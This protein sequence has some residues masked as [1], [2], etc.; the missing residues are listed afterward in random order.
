MMIAAHT[1]LL[2]VAL[3]LLSLAHVLS[4]QTTNA[5]QQ[6]AFAGLRSIAQ[7]GQVNGVKADAAGNLFL[8]LNQGDGVRLLKTDNAGNA[9]LAQ[10]RLGAA[11]D[12]GTALALDPAGNVFVA[13]T[14][15]SSAM[16]ATPGAAIAAR[17]DSST[18]S[19]VARFDTSLNPVF[20]TFTG[21][22]RIAATSVA[23]TADA[24]FVSGIT[25][26]SNLPV[27]PHG[28]QQSPAFASTQNGFVEKFSASGT[29]LLYATY[30]TGA[31]GDTTPQALVA[32]SAD[33]LYIAGETTASG[34][35]TVAALVPE[36]LSNPSGFLTKLTPAG[37][38]ILFSTFVPGNGLTSL[39]LDS[40][41]STLLASGSVNLGQFP[42]DMV[43]SL[44][45]P[46][47]AYQ[48]LLRLPTSGSSVLSA[49]LL[50]PA[51]ASFVAAAP[52]G[53]AWTAGTM[54]APMLPLQPLASVGDGFAIHTTGS[55][56]VD[57]TARFGGLPNQSPSYASLPTLLTAITA[58]PAG[59]AIVAGA[60]QPTA[61]SA[62]LASETYDLPLRNSSTPA[63]PS[64][65]V[66]AELPSSAC[67]GSLCAGSAAFLAKL[68]PNTAAPALAFS[69]GD[70]PFVVLRN[71]GS[72]EATN[73]QLAANTS[74]LSS[75]CP[76]NLPAGGECELLLSGGGAGDLTATT[77]NAGSQSVSLPA[78]SASAPLSSIVFL[79]K[80]LDFGIQTS[81]SPAST[82]ILTISNL[83]SVS[84]TFT[85]ALD[86]TSNPKNP[87]TYPFTEASSDCPSAGNALKVLAAGASCHITI[88]F[89]AP[90]DAT[91]EGFVTYNWLIGARDVKL[92]GYEQAA[93]LSASASQ[94]DFG[95]QFG[96]VS[97][98][99]IHLPRYLFLSNAS[100][101]PIAHTPVSLPAGSAFT[102]TDA[103]PLSL[104]AGTV[105]RIRIDY[106]GSR[107]TSSDSA[108]LALDQG[109]SVLLTGRTLPPATTTGASV[110]P[111]LT[112]TPSS[113][114]FANAVV[115][116]GVSGET[117]TVTIANTG[118]SAFALSLSL[119]GD[120]TDSTSCGATLAGGQTCAVVLSFV[121]TAPGQRQGLLAVTAGAGTTPFYVSITASATGLLPANNG[122]LDFGS[123]TVNQPVTKFFKVSQPLDSFSA[124]ATGPYGII[125]VEEAGFGPGNPP[126]SSFASS[127]TGS[128]HN[129]YLGIQ[130]R[131][132]AV[133]P[134]PG[135]LTL[136][137]V[138]GGSPYVLSLTGTGL[139]LAGLLLT[140]VTQDFG[141]VPLH[142]ASG[143][144]LFTLT[145]LIP[146]ASSVTLSGPSVSGDFSL[147]S[148][149]TGAPSCAGTL[150]Y[151]TSCIVAVTFSP[152]A[153]GTRTGSL[154]LSGGGF[155]V[156]AAL[157]GQ[158]TADPGLAINPLALTFAN[159]PGST[160][161]QQN[162]TLTNTGSAALEVGT[163]VSSSA[164]FSTSSPCGSLA[165]GA[166]C[167]I[168]V[169]FLPGSAIASGTLSIPVTSPPGSS[170]AVTYPVALSG[171]YTSASAGIQIVP[172]Q[173][174][175]GPFPVDSFGTER[176]YTLNNLTS[177]SLTLAVDIPRNFVLTSAPCGGLAPNA[178]CSFQL[179]FV[180]LTA[181]T[182]PG[183]IA[184]QGTPS[185]GSSP[186]ATFGYA[187]GYGT[188]SGA[189]TVTGG[190]LVNGVYDFGQVTSG[191]AV[192]H[193]FTLTNNNP[194]GSPALTVRRITS[195]PPFLATTN[196]GSA[197]AV[198]QGCTV[199]V[200]YT[201]V[202]QVA[203]GTSSAP[204]N[205]DAGT[206]TI[207]SD[208]ASSPNIINLT[209]RASPLS[210]S[211]PVNPA[212]LATFTLTQGSL[213]FPL[214]TVGNVSAAQTI[215]LA[216]TGTATLHVGG[217]FTSSD[218]GVVSDCTTVLPGA[219]C[220]IDVTAQPQSAGPHI[221]SLEISSDAATALEF[222]SLF[223]TGAASPLVF[224]PASLDFGSVL[225]GASST[226]HVQ[227]TNTSAAAITFNS[228]AGFG[229]YT[230]AGSCPG[231]GG[232]LAANTSC[233][234]EV[235]FRPSGPGVRSG[236]LSLASSAS[237]LPLSVS[238]TGIGTQSQLIVSPSS[239]A[240]GSIVV[241]SSANLTLNLSNN[242]S[243]PVTNLSLSVTGPFSLTAP[244]PTSAIAAGA[245]CA[246]QITFTPTATGPQTGTLTVTSSDPGSP[247]AVPLTGA[248]VQGG[249]FTLSVN[250][251]ASAAVSV[252]SGQPASYQ[253]SINPTGGFTGTVALTCAPIVA[254]QFASCSILPASVT[255]SA[256]SSQSSV[257]TIN[258]IT[259]AASA[260][261]QR[262]FSFLRAAMLCLLM[263]GFVALVLSGRRRGGPS[264]ALMPLALLGTGLLL[265]A[266]GCGGNSSDINLRYSPAG[267]YQY[268]VTASSTSGVQI[269]ET[270]TLNL[271]ITPR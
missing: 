118:G 79:P 77:S 40:T 197:L 219:S 169:S 3:A 67:S 113:V 121:P 150:A 84:Q 216:N 12:V 183:S 46:A 11:G 96:N 120:F 72:G 105:C 61:S 99:G 220:A 233:T 178:S 181:G 48:V 146:Q 28:I 235:I 16:T 164:S 17:T 223:T 151:T 145:N 254:A 237:T 201:P 37:D 246:A 95:T 187:E 260:S 22:S 180:P 49:T 166:S 142:S 112:V 81:A 243:A 140:P 268:Q 65:V 134:Q 21:G 19:F 25:F 195:Q 14:T 214:T 58:D 4:A 127:V 30:L 269:T 203:N 32:D 5:P 13:G 94:I 224:V 258:T 85:S 193:T 263:P 168:A 152:A 131:P 245:S 267:S 10:V 98:S 122:S 232:T 47:A 70:L 143:T 63:L 244:C 159:V 20:V 189:L 196:C 52:N 231:S 130:F 199:T 194:S 144:Q 162:V 158:G 41:G 147:L 222:A 34:F 31:S 241:G 78:Y 39:T 198:G 154:A 106:L 104:A 124:S 8:L 88:G 64:T 53:G 226:L 50:A 215:T 239:L 137:S 26:A 228:L 18:Q 60:V 173:G 249:G 102:V 90:P 54:A 262:P 190:L 74:S 44:V 209:G 7:Q 35:P 6:L 141:S 107:P 42:V 188:G 29:S 126:P 191:Q 75:N 175:F 177:K 23:A 186:V 157:S 257:V 200:T 225:V 139:P 69:T 92:T 87:Q 182:L 86:V 43:S 125:L 251:G 211:S 45:A 210:V 56:T 89:T 2:S 161:S 132:T 218:F 136:S 266:Q 170:Q 163:P 176:T 155:S 110:N 55:G 207:E 117:Q 208:A 24:V 27:T 229:D 271:N 265:A 73:L 83:G 129:C 148:S 128:C 116:T 156:A 261:L 179:A 236:S 59:E 71:L 185:D 135:T 174:Q 238:L 259:S 93:A 38:G 217:V 103:C 114:S 252:I 76:P 149:S 221:A 247:V 66:D 138:T 270:V 160:A 115:V 250:G 62:L 184:V 36:S 82:R 119:T 206:L 100:A 192:A 255:L 234:A 1:R 240:F 205:S 111:N 123:I 202:N 91:N 51:A 213:A 108:T 230:V 172:G 9:I 68:D 264:G 256:G 248:G 167:S 33:N 133:G 97:G 212:P 253:L 109:L 171:T 153:L 101:S 15:T 57:R 204:A 165:A 227:I 242:G 80:E